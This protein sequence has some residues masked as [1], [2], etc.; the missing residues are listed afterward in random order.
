M[1]KLSKVPSTTTTISVA[2]STAGSGSALW[3]VQ[4][5]LHAAA[6]RIVACRNSSRPDSEPCAMVTKGSRPTGPQG[7]SAS[8]VGSMPSPGYGGGGAG[9]PT[10]KS[11]PRRYTASEMSRSP[12]SLTSA[13]SS[14]WGGGAPGWKSDA[15]IAT[16]SAMSTLPAPS[17]SPRTKAWAGACAEHRTPI[18]K[19]SMMGFM[20]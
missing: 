3:R 2:K 10:R 6:S 5:A 19:T 15:R 4:N 20:A 1:P 13:A 7:G 14:Q 17:W 8:G 12:S 9:D 11:A 18:A 16:A